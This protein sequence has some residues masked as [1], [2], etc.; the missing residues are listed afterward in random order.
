MSNDTSLLLLGAAAGQHLA[1]A[2]VMSAT[3]HANGKTPSGPVQRFPLEGTFYRKR[4]V[5]ERHCLARGD[6]ASD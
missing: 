2:L 6:W 1:V 3:L 4:E 5:S